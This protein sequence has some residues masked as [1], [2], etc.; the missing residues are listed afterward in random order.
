[1]LASQPQSSRRLPLPRKKNAIDP[2]NLPYANRREFLQQSCF[3]VAATALPST[4]G[5]FASARVPELRFHP[6]YRAQL[7][8]ESVLLNT[9]AGLDQFVT[10][11]YH[12]QIAGILAQWTASLLRSPKE[13]EAI[14][15][16]F[17]AD[18]SGYAPT[19][20]ES[21]TPLPGPIVRVT[22]KPLQRTLLERKAFVQLWRQNLEPF[23]RILTAEFQITR[24][25]AAQSSP[26]TLPSTV[27][28]RV[29]YELVGTG[30]G[31]HRRQDIGQ[32]DLEWQNSA[33]QFLLRRWEALEETTSYTAN[34]VY[35]D[36]TAKAFSSN[37]S[38]SA[39][40]QRG[41][42]H[43]RTVLDVACGIDIY[44]HNGVSVGDING[45]GFDDLY[46]C[47]PAGLPNRLYRNRG[48]GTF[49]DVTEGSGVDLSTTP[50][51]PS[52][53]TSITT[54]IST[55]S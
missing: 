2:G 55:S 28:T 4:L 40:L 45:N 49:E 39:Q 13:T 18:F 36:T 5:A 12:D 51:A 53:P 52:S 30:P 23:S 20:V 44:G 7:P 14:E 41:V 21:R 33:G 6:H 8:L 37:D 15:R 10:E 35:V 22:K 32:W 42:D 34:P 11:K 29:R 16:H 48:D 1:M 19:A 43:W 17:A 50:P 46:I 24:I 3:A 9:K 54:A 27:K 26:N 31:V 38:Y 25:D 47:Q